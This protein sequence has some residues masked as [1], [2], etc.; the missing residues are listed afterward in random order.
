MR[1]SW[2]C[3]DCNA[4]AAPGAAE[5]PSLVEFS[6]ELHEDTGHEIVSTGSDRNRPQTA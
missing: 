4:R 5:D 3:L 2:R 6:R 1:D